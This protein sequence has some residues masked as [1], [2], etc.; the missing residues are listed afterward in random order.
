M[1]LRLSPSG[2]DPRGP[3]RPRSLRLGAGAALPKVVGS[4]I[5]PRAAS[6]GQCRTSGMSLRPLQNGIDEVVDRRS[7]GVQWEVEQGP[8]GRGDA[9]PFISTDLMPSACDLGGP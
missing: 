9:I 2:P 3:A 4:C 5:A 7:Q 8:R 6:Q 1:V